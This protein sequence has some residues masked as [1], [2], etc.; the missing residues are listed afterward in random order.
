MVGS[1]TDL[2]QDSYEDFNIMHDDH[3]VSDL[4]LSRADEN[5]SKDCAKE[6]TKG[7]TLCQR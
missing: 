7:L 5:S 6:L 2:G 3:L 1:C 4:G